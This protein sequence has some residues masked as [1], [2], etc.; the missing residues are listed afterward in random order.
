MRPHYPRQRRLVAAR[1]GLPP[2]LKVLA[3]Q[4]LG[5]TPGFGRHEVHRLPP[6]RR[7]APD[8]ADPSPDDLRGRRDEPQASDGVLSAREVV[9][10]LRQCR[11]S[12]SPRMPIACLAKAAGLSR[13]TLYVAMN[14]GEASE[15]TCAALTPILEEIAAGALAFERNGQ[16]WQQVE[17]MPPA[18]ELAQQQQFGTLGYQDRMVRAGDWQPGHQCSTCRCRQYTAVILHG[19]VW[20]F[21][22]GC[23][24]WQTAGMG[25]QPVKPAARRRR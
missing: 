24:P 20:Y 5:I 1:P 25:A 18:D 16:Q 8:T 10:L 17:L 15:E 11:Y 9:N 2:L 7:R 6:P 19:A 3:G 23:L 22:N 13:E 12:R 4:A 21:C 14:T